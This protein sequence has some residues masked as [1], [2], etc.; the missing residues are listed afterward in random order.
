MSKELIILFFVQ[1]FSAVLI[2]MGIGDLCCFKFGTIKIQDTTT[3]QIQS[4]ETDPLQSSIP[5]T[6]ETREL[7]SIVQHRRAK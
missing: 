4:T 2:F 5:Q 3:A 7:T 6:Q 1:I